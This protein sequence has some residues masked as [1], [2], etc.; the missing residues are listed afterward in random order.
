MSNPVNTDFGALEEESMLFKVCVT[1]SKETAF[2][3]KR[4]CVEE[5][6]V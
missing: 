4:I 1:E 3:N 5:G 6:L 2:P